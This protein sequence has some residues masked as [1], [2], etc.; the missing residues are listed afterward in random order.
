MALSGAVTSLA[1]AADAATTLLTQASD[2]KT[3]LTPTMSAYREAGDNLNALLK[4]RAITET[5]D[6]VDRL[7]AASAGSMENI[8]GI[9]KDA[10]IET[11]AMVAPKTKKQKALEFAPP[12]FKLGITL[13]CFISKTC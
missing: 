1:G 11:D 2:E 9:T 6:N 7:T 5:L 12:A 10:K 8:E 3:G 13:M 4:E